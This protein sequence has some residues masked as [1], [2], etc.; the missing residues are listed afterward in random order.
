MKYAYKGLISELLNRC[1]SEFERNSQWPQEDVVGMGADSD[2]DDLYRASHNTTA[3][4]T[5]HLFGR[6]KRKAEADAEAQAHQQKAAEKKRAAMRHLT[7]ALL[8]GGSLERSE[9]ATEARPK[10]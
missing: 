1:S 4:L 2:C 3:V 10:P 9:T 6:L 7:V 8:W 5:H